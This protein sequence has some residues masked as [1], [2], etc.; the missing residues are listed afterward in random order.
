MYSWLNFFWRSCV[1]FHSHARCM[2]CINNIQIISLLPQQINLLI[3]CDFI[4]NTTRYGVE[5][6]EAKKNS[7]SMDYVRIFNCWELQH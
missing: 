2:K 6:A 1:Y 5:Q 7:R 4:G 3:P